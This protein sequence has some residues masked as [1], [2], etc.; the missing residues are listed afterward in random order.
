MGLFCSVQCST[1]STA[2]T[3]FDQTAHNVRYTYIMLFALSKCSHHRT[4]CGTSI[5]MG[6]GQL[7]AQTHAYHT[8]HKSSIA[9]SGWFVGVRLR[10]FNDDW[11]FLSLSHSLST[12]LHNCHPQFVFGQCTHTHTHTSFS[13][14]LML[15]GVKIIRNLAYIFIIH[16]DPGTSSGDSP[17]KRNAPWNSY[18]NI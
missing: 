16:T 8:S 2:F 13:V 3:R 14:H 15:V 7:T 6:E 18:A 5:F 10:P 4:G 11:S 1:Y 17:G 9:S 12:E